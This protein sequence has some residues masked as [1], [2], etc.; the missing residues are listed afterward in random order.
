MIQLRKVPKRKSALKI[1]R[2]VIATVQCWIT[3][4]LM[5]VDS[6]ISNDT[7]LIFD[8]TTGK[9]TKRVGKLLL[10][11]PVRELHNDL[12]AAAEKGELPGVLDANGRIT[13]SDTSLRNILPPQADVWVRD[14]S[15]TPKP[16]TISELL[17]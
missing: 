11:I 2:E 10:Q 13:I 4:H 16:P 9:K 6:P 1:T 8:E 15:H 3:E 12:V 17:A 14:V 5:V 7:L